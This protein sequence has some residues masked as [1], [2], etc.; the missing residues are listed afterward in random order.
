MVVVGCALAWYLLVDRNPPKARQQ[1]AQQVRKPEP[2]E[3][4]VRVGVGQADTEE[5]P[6]PLP[7][8]VPVI[9]PRMTPGN[10]PQLEAANPRNST[11][12]T[13]QTTAE[14]VD[15]ITE[16]EPQV[17]VQL[18]RAAGELNNVTPRRPL[19]R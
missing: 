11:A 10:L 7:P 2:Q 3:R 19:R 16:Q 15:P 6:L 14:E 13:A 12:V 9:K 4:K 18:A 17:P 8:P 1:V 5:Q